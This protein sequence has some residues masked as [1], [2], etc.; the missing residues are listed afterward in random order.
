MKKD[1]IEFLKALIQTPSPTGDERVISQLF[2]EHMNEFAVH[3]FTDKFNNCAFTAT[4]KIEGGTK[5]MISGH[6]DE[7]SYMISYID[8]SGLCNIV[9]C[10]GE[11]RRVLP[12]SWLAVLND[13]GE[14]MYPAVVCYKPIHVQTDGEYDSIAKVEDM[15]IDLG[16]DS[17]E[18][19]EK[20]GV[21]VGTRV[22]YDRGQEVLEFGPK[23]DKIVGPGLDD[24]VGVYITSEVLRRIDKDLLEENKI[25]LWGV[26]MAQEETG[27]RGSKVAAKRIN[28]NI[29]IDIDVCP[30]TGKEV[31]IDTAKF[32][33]IK[34]GKGVVI[35]NGPG[36]SPRIISKLVALAKQYNIPYQ[37]GVC[38]AGGTNTA[39]IQEFSFDCETVLLSIP[40]HNM[41][42]PTEICHWDDIESCI[43]LITK[44]IEEGDL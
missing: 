29:S 16:F 14:L 19:L 44:Y 1:N 24:K 34:F 11:D 39:A 9:R 18:E 8:S 4:N 6:Y 40:N 13:N 41:H 27:L 7:L 23:G 32:G 20:A 10:S 30:I 21:H 17:K 37:L 28:P 38:R 15:M 25:E 36:K 2:K 42:Q 22:V 35:E 31:D 12:G 3:R 26:G 5:V 43:Q 33:D